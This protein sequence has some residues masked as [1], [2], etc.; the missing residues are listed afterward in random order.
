A[1]ARVEAVPALPPQHLTAVPDTNTPY[2]V[3]TTTGG[4][5]KRRRRAGEVAA[6]AAAEPATTVETPAADSEMTASRLGAF[7]RG[8]R[9]GRDTMTTEGPEY[10]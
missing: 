8:T 10:Q 7:A 5:P 9:I 1:P 3:G 6:K 2:V 4:L